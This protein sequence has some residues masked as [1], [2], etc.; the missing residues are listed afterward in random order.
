MKRDDIKLSP[1]AV[2]L[3]RFLSQYKRCINAKRMLEH[4]RQEIMYEFDS[5][6]SAV[7]MDGMPRG[8]SSNIGCAALAFRLDDI[9][10]KIR[11]QME[12]SLSVLTEIMDI[13]DY[14]PENSMERMII[15]YKYIDRFGWEKISSAANITRTPAIRYWRKGLYKLLE[16]KKIKQIL[17]E[18]G[19]SEKGDI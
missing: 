18:Y 5:P 10:E 12:R 13:I 4:R 15:E 9:N 1:E 8:S 7:Q 3:D 19:N 17:A 11:R 16:F 2:K 6:L 14:L